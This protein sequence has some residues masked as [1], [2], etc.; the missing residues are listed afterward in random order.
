MTAPP[1]SHLP[2]A[3][4]HSVLSG[5]ALE[6]LDFLY[7]RRIAPQTEEFQDNTVFDDRELLG[8]IFG[9]SS[10]DRLNQTKFRAKIF[11]HMPSGWL[12]EAAKTVSL[13]ASD[14]SKIP[15]LLGRIPWKAGNDKAIALA[16][17]LGLPVTALPAP[18]EYTEPPLVQAPPSPFKFL[19]SYQADIVERAME[20]LRPHNS[21]CLVQMPTGSGK[22][23]V[24]MDILARLFRSRSG[25]LRVLWLAHVT[26]LCSQAESAFRHVWA[27]IGTRD[28][29]LARTNRDS[30]VLW[31]ATK[32]VFVVSTIQKMN[33]D[34]KATGSLPKFDVVVMDEA[35]KAIAPRY[36]AVIEAS[37]NPIGGR[38]IGLT[39]TPGRDMDDSVENQAVANMFQNNLCGL[40]FGSDEGVMEA[41]QR[42][43]ILARVVRRPIQTELDIEI[44]E[45]DVASILAGG[46]YS[47]EFLERLAN[48]RNRNLRIADELLR[49]ARR[50]MRTVV[51]ATNVEQSKMFAAFLTAAGHA[52]A[53]VDGN[54][55][56]EIRN[57]RVQQ[58]I[59]GELRFLL[60]FDVFSTGFDAPK[61]DAVVIARPTQSIVLYSQ[62]IGRGLRGPMVGGTEICHL[63]DVVDNLARYNSD[64]DD[65]YQFF[66][67]YWV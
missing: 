64:L 33:S 41:L 27:T 58:F 1:F 46:D 51:F 49:L 44:T 4:L 65:V 11:N 29:T 50:G 62:M 38:L 20:N 16:G 8:K 47:L 24:A 3:I 66:E 14:V 7:R 17:Q 13:P 19:H 18:A 22:T 53:H 26:E 39:A 52:A 57:W 54:T 42:R 21:R 63:I 35:H 67:D 40:S 43:G 30:R 55:P 12:K 2:N 25:G 32:D 34:L 6:Q 31:D 59:D 60:N 61:T 5:E 45:S 37:L 10:A 9:F 23:R 36:Q 56:T 28:V 48:D 15:D